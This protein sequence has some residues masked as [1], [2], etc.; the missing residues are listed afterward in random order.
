MEATDPG[1]APLLQ[2]WRLGL[3]ALVLAVLWLGEALVPIHAGRSH[4]V[5]HGATNLALAG[6]NTLLV[7]A[8]AAALFAVTA[9]A[10]AADFGLVRWLGLTGWVQWL[11]AIVLFDAWQY[12]WHRLNHRMPLLWR[13]HALHHADADMD[14]T[15]GVRF[16]SVEVLLSFA[17]RLVVVPLLGMTV[18][19][20]LLYELLALP[21]ILFHHSNL[22]VPPALDAALRVVLVTPAMHLVHHSRWQPETNS[23]YTS[24]LSV[25]DRLFGTFRLREKPQEIELG[26]DGYS[27][28][29][30]RNLGGVLVAPFR[31]RP[32]PALPLTPPAAAPPSGR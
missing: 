2:Q 23:N 29:E 8:V 5:A 30:W 18:P 11:A 21:V 26:L 25:W 28:T 22:R 16:H 7:A 14:V 13:F 27:E 12:A 24:F 17:A 15:S 20:L 32:A 19:Q 31:R 10:A 4:R 3:G 6:L 9:R 1:L